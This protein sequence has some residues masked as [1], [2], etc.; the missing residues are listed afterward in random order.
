MTLVVDVGTKAEI[1]LATRDR[2]LACSS[3]TGPAF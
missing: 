2:L 1:V 3:P